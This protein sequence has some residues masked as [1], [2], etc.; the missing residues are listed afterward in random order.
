MIRL[1]DSCLGNR[2][3]PAYMIAGL[4]PDEGGELCVQEAYTPE[5]TCWGCGELFWL[6]TLSTTAS[7]TPQLPKICLSLIRED[8]YTLSCIQF[9]IFAGQSS[10]TGLR[11]QSFRTQNG[12]KSNVTF[13]R[14]FQAFPGIINGGLVS[15]V[16][17]CQGNWTSAIALMDASQLP[18]PPFTLSSAIQV[19]QTRKLKFLPLPLRIGHVLDSLREGLA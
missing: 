4:E 6:K 13:P 2:L 16:F 18:K 15:T 8:K 1:K 14:S 11:L 3:H 10:E 12:L 17:D 19:F 7:E 5:S 9:C